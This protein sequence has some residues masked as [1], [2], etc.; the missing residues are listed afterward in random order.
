MYTPE[1]VLDNLREILARNGGLEF[2]LKF[3]RENGGLFRS[4]GAIKN[5]LGLAWQD[6]LAKVGAR[7]RTREMHVTARSQRLGFLAKVTREEM[8]AELD[9]AWQRKG[10]CPSRADFNQGSKQLDSDLY[11]RRFGSWSKA[12]EALCELKKIPVPRIPGAPRIACEGDPNPPPRRHRRAP[13]TND[14]LIAEILEVQ[15]KYPATPISYG[16]YK[17][18]GGTYHIDTFKSH[19][20]SWTKAVREAGGVP[21]H[22]TYS[23]D[24][25]FD[26]MQRLWEKLGR[27]PTRDE[28]KADGSISPGTYANQF[29]SW[30]KAIH[31]F[32]EDRNSD[33]LEPEE[34]PEAPISTEADIRVVRNDSPN[35]S[36]AIEP[37]PFDKPSPLKILRKTGRAVGKRLRW[38]V[39]VRDNFTCRGCGRSREK[40]GVVLHADHVTA[41][42]N[43]GET[44]FENLQTLCEDCNVGKSNL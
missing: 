42:S 3:Y 1:E 13:A 9:L 38:R 25:L 11:I 36:P 31:A 6:A 19:F 26:E 20:G 22:P 35:A 2:D 29:G 8:L 32:C 4:Y 15:R 40:H 39:F 37:I 12:I 34:Q 10:R 33:R 14:G 17:A 16:L 41:Y 23:H 21:A 7:K 24:E 43:G 28:M 27:Q 5:N 44:V 18:G 30:I